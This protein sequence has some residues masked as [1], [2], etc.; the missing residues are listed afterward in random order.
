LVNKLEIAGKRELFQLLEEYG[1]IPSAIKYYDEVVLERRYLDIVVFGHYSGGKTSFLNAIFGISDPEQRLPVG[2]KPTTLKNWK[3]SYGR[4]QEIELCDKEGDILERLSIEDIKK[5]SEAEKA[6]WIEIADHFHAKIS[7]P[8]L[9]GKEEKVLIWDTPGLNEPSKGKGSNN[10]SNNSKLEELKQLIHRSEIAILVGSYENIKCATVKK[11]LSG[12]KTIPGLFMTVITNSDAEDRFADEKERYRKEV[13]ESLK[14]IFPK[15]RHLDIFCVDSKEVRKQLESFFK[16][17]MDDRD[18]FDMIN[19]LEKNGWRRIYAKLVDLIHR[20]EAVIAA[21]MKNKHETKVVKCIQAIE[22][23][24]EKLELLKKLP[25]ENELDRLKHQ[26]K[27]KRRGK[28][29]KLG[30]ELFEA[31]LVDIFNAMQKD[32]QEESSVVMRRIKRHL[33]L[34]VKEF[35][36]VL[37]KS[38][39]KKYK[40]LLDEIKT[41]SGI[42]I[43]TEEHTQKRFIYIDP[44]SLS[45]ASKCIKKIING[46]SSDHLSGSRTEFVGEPLFL[47]QKDALLDFIGIKS[48]EDRISISVKE[49]TNKA[50]SLHNK[51]INRKIKKKQKE[52]DSLDAEIE[53][54]KKNE[55]WLIDWRKAK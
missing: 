6:R 9:K 31:L 26:K 7:S 40:D 25:I 38:C 14:S 18:L 30:D 33:Q 3:L 29:V 20:S 16:G 32:Q 47:E 15:E 54:H 42:K 23:K 4:K 52:L 55:Q 41:T 39:R 28:R 10:S 48:I 34:K 46:I 11:F 49:R 27:R 43:P 12:I 2:R 45:K 1:A 5:L 19:V 8:L 22:E 53:I 44:R 17:N 21:R 36:A 50:I 35:S 37:N 24:I 51:A 13:E